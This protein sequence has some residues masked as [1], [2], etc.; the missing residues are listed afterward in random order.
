MKCPN[1]LN[2]KKS[3]QGDLNALFPHDTCCR[4][5][6]RRITRRFRPGPRHTHARVDRSAVAD[7][8]VKK[9]AYYHRYARRHYRR[10]YYGYGYNYGYHRPYYGYGYRRTMVIMVMGVAGA[11]KRQEHRS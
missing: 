4:S 9:V 11:T 2:P 7:T 8:Q 1:L 6:E 5:T 3:K 10:N